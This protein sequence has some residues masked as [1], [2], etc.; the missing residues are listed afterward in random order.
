MSFEKW[1]TALVQSFS[2]ARLTDEAFTDLRRLLEAQRY[3]L[4]AFT[5]CGWFFSELSGIEPMQN[6]A[7]ACRAL[8]LGISESKQ[9]AT[10][11]EFLADLALAR[12]NIGK[13]TGAT[14]F[15]K[16]ILPYF[17]HNHM[18]AFIVAME[19]MFG[20][21]PGTSIQRYGYDCTV[22]AFGML[23]GGVDVNNTGVFQVAILHHRYSK[24]DTFQVIVDCTGRNEPES[25]VVRNDEKIKKMG[26]S[27]VVALKTNPTAKHFL[28]SSIFATLQE[29]IAAVYLKKIT[30]KSV[31]Q[32]STWFGGNENDLALLKSFYPAIPEYF[33][34]SIGFV[35][36]QQWDNVFRKSD[37]ITKAGICCIELFALFTKIRQHDVEI[38]LTFSADRCEKQLL[39]ELEKMKRHLTADQCENISLL[40]DIVDLYH[41]PVAKHRLEDI[42]FPVL[43]NSVATLHQQV[44]NSTTKKK[45]DYD[46]ELLVKI[47]K[48]AHRMNF[49]TDQFPLT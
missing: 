16:H 14:L 35:L 33:R 15:T 27:F 10:L 40:M 28:I 37:L 43:T 7:Y 45:V 21:I 23:N 5:S 38:D 9:H 41:L 17:Y 8:Q 46:K 22:K 1:K 12:S 42:F 6:L 26:N 29:D 25:W 36:Q 3:M 31:K 19:K 32:F 13:E 11:E 47:L 34:R 30:E 20:I 24:H 2:N 44:V 18:M 39:I 4:F 48:F 49:N